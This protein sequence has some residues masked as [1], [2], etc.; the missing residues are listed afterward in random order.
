[1]SRSTYS[2]PSPN[3]A[4]ASRPACAIAAGKRRLVT[5]GFHADAA[6]ACRW[7]DEYREA[8]PSSRIRYGGFT[9]IGGRLAG[10]HWN[11]GTRRDMTRGDLGTERGDHIGRRPDE[12]QPASNAGS[13]KRHDFRRGTRSPGWIASAPVSVAALSTA[14]GR[15]ITIE[16]QAPGRSAPRGRRALG[17]ERCC[18]RLNTRPPTRCQARGT[19]G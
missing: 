14:V 10:N 17:A 16:R 3:A 2:V 11:A 6:T 1:M 15:Q 19:H 7:L 18:P 4:I 5:H 12:D 13:R 8:Y 9:L